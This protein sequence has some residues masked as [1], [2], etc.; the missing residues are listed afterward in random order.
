[1]LGAGNL[2]ND[3]SGN[4]RLWNGLGSA[5]VPHT[6]SRNQQLLSARVVRSS[7]SQSPRRSEGVRTAGGLRAIVDA[8]RSVMCAA[9]L[10]GR[11]PTSVA[12]GTDVR[13]FIPIDGLRP[14]SFT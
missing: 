8:A 5:H 13:G 14:Q 6:D 10:L 11:G 9:V 12:V 7:S 1:M 3:G 4:Y 2:V